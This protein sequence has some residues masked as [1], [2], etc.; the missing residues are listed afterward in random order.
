MPFPARAFLS[1]MCF[2]TV[3]ATLRMALIA[4]ILEAAAAPVT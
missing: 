3:Q 2:R 1:S 4:A